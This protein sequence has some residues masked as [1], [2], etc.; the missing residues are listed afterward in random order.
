MDTYVSVW[1]LE[2]TV[3][4]FL[5]FIEAKSLTEHSACQMVSLASQVL[6]CRQ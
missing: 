6:D 5:H 2:L 3:D 1:R 4:V